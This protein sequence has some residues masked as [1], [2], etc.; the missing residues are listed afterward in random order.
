MLQAGTELM[1]TRNVMLEQMKDMPA[2][3]PGVNKEELLEEVAK[4]TMHDDWSCAG[5]PPKLMGD[6]LPGLRYGASL[7]I[8]PKLLVLPCPCP[9]GYFNKAWRDSSGSLQPSGL[10][11][12]WPK[13]EVED[14]V[15][16]LDF[17]NAFRFSFQKQV[18]DVHT[19]L[20]PLFHDGSGSPSGADSQVTPQQASSPHDAS[21]SDSSFTSNSHDDKTPLSFNAMGVDIAGRLATAAGIGGLYHPASEPYSADYGCAKGFMKSNGPL[22]DMKPGKRWWNMPDHS[23]VAVATPCP[24]MLGYTVGVP[25][26]PEWQAGGLRLGDMGCAL[27]MLAGGQSLPSMLAVSF[28]Q[29]KRWDALWHFLAS[30]GIVCISFH[31]KLML[32][33]A[34]A[35]AAQRTRAARSGHDSLALLGLPS[36]SGWATLFWETP[37]GDFSFCLQVSEVLETESGNIFSAGC[38]VITLRPRLVLTNASTLDIELCLEEHRRLRLAGDQSIEVHWCPREVHEHTTTLRFR[39]LREGCETAWSGSVVC[40]DVSAGLSAFAIPAVEDGKDETAE[41]DTWSVEVTPDRGALAVSFKQGSDYVARNLVRRSGATLS[42]QPAGCRH[43]KDGSFAS[44]PRYT[45]GSP[46]QV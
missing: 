35:S 1:A 4:H 15:P 31:L 43:G 12:K 18:Q 20:P 24:C 3:P 33:L 42:V 7:E 13:P 21:K 45:A 41:Q 22:G 40:G 30:Q 27:V 34:A 39:P 26:V 46:L 5:G 9:G 2:I 32:S 16:K 25:K 19:S 38:Q 8:R 6:E 14:F 10:W 36:P 11:A 29:H 17:R 44:F 23:E 28:A 37:C